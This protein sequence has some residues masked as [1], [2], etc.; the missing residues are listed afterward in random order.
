MIVLW[1]SL[2][3]RWGNHKW[4]LW[5]ATLH[6]PPAMDCQSELDGSWQKWDDNPGWSMN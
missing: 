1:L 4:L 2:K 6:H 3:N 5:V